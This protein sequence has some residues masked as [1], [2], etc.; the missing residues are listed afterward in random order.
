V[1]GV[2]SLLIVVTLGLIITRVATVALR[3]TGL[4][5]EVARFQAR[6]A[7]SGVGFTTIESE[8]ILAHPARRR[9]IQ[10]LM[11]LSGAGVAG[12]LASLL[13]SFTGT[14]GY[15]Q[16][17]GRIAVLVVGLFILWRLASSSWVDARLSRAI[18][19]ALRRWTD[20]EARDYV[21]LLQIGGSYSI[22]EIEVEHDDWVEG[23]PLR[24]LRLNREGVVVLGVR[25]ADGRY[26]GVPSGATTIQAGDTVIVYGEAQ[27]L[28]ELRDRKEGV[29]GDEAHER[30]S[31]RHRRLRHH[32]EDHLAQEGRSE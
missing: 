15:R 5:T 12:T 20:L 7:F 26:V 8:D 13:L 16:P 11:L 17:A 30:A 18:E 24:D 3:T 10:S 14:S 28:D 22:D 9:I 21:R 31:A 32:Q 23:R 29:S 1:I 6:S 4:S 27:Q 19:R 2:V 25:R